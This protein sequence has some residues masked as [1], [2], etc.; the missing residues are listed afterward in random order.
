MQLNEQIIKESLR[1][2]SVT[3]KQMCSDIGLTETALYR[4]YKSGGMRVSTQKKIVEY[5]G[6]DEHESVVNL[7]SNSSLVDT[8]LV[9]RLLRRI[10]ELTLE[11]YVLKSKLGKCDSTLFA[12]SA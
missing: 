5:L 9:D 6:L 1:R 4:F 11:N 8:N 2:N 10:E 12:L 3:A 7:E